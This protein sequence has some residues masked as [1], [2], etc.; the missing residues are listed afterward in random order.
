MEKIN[1]KF[2]EEFTEYPG[3]RSRSTGDGSAEEFYMI[4]RKTQSSRSVVGMQAVYLA[5]TCI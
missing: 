1:L 2:I 5:K 4:Q 3:G